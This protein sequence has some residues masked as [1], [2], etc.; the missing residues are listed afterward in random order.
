MADSEEA[1]RIEEVRDSSGDSR[2]E[3]ADKPAAKNTPVSPAPAPLMH[4]LTQNKVILGGFFI[5]IAVTMAGFWNLSSNLRMLH[6]R[7]KRMR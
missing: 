3:A 1:G 2:S 4:F 6:G 5:N 7:G